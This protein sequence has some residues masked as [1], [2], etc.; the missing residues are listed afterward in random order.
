M[1]IS[2]CIIT[3]NEEENIKE[4]I[5]N[6]KEL[7]DE[8][9]VVDRFSDDKTKEI[10][11]SMGVSFYEK[12][13]VD[14]TTQKNTAKELAKNGWVFFLDAD[15]RLSDSLKE[16]LKRLKE[17][18]KIDEDGFYVKRRAMYVGKW[19]KH[20]GWYPDKSIRLFRKDKGTFYGK[21]VHEGLKLGGKIGELK[22]DIL[23][24]AYSSF[25]EHFDKTK[26]Y[27]YLS[28]LR[29]IDEGKSF[30]ILK[31]IFSPFFRFIKHF[32]LRLGFLDG[33][34]GLVI[35]YLS[36][37]YVFL[38]YVYLWELKKGEGPSH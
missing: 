28:A 18:D 2:F 12:E 7:A 16:E 5:E 32:F 22:G 23:H 31:L 10:A 11:L 19:I 8:I 21:Y 24:F 36:S 34:H 14:Y 3:Y 9:V 1:K 6:I 33:V 29:M 15:E 25:R 17:R 35:S 30:S 13:W 38:K 27:A 26:K 20:S 4:L 37:Y